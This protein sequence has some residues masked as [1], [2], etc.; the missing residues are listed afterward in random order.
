MTKIKIEAPYHE[1]ENAGHI[2]YIEYPGDPSM[3]LKAFE[4]LVRAMVDNNAGY[5]AINHPNDRDPAC[6]YV[7]IIYNDCPHC[8]RNEKGIYKINVKKQERN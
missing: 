7:G 6:G 1:L 8:H 4:R 2:L 3:N 5:M